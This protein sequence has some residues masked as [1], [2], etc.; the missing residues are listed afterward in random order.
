M[1]GIG[2]SYTGLSVKSSNERSGKDF[3][4]NFSQNQSNSRIRLFPTRNKIELH[5][6]L[7]RNALTHSRNY[8]PTEVFS[9]GVQ[10][11]QVAKVSAIRGFT[12]P[13][14]AFRFM[15]DLELD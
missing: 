7:G 10:K 4:S 12:Q 8:P 3:R 9:C 5:L 6:N 2:S 15:A 13:I 11:M 14:L 1:F